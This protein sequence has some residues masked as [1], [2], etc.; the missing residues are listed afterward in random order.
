MSQDQESPSPYVEDL[1]TPDGAVM[2]AQRAL[3]ASLA[4]L[5]TK[6]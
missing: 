4:D 5:V 3:R 6:G 2:A 1:T